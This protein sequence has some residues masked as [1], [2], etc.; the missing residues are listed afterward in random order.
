[1]NPNP[2]NTV[3]TPPPV[4]PTP[5]SIPPTPPPF[6]PTPTPKPPM[7]NG[8]AH[9]KMKLPLGILLVAVIIALV[10]LGYSKYPN[11]F[12][13]TNLPAE[14]VTIEKIDFS[15][16]E[17]IGKLPDGFPT[18]I[19]VEKSNLIESTKITYSEQKSVL[20][21]VSFNSARQ[22][23]ELY[24]QYK[25]FLSA[26]NGFVIDN[27]VKTVERMAFQATKAGTKDNITVAI[28]PQSSGAILVQ[29]S[30]VS[31]L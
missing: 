11:L 14:K 2:I 5:S 27:Q 22:S 21:S 17:N 19:P 3:P 28:T 26:K 29:I 31:K 1:M 20:Y 10:Y 12:K 24:A 9:S 23:E 4:T 25:D 8:D 15:K 30:Y 16:V 13:K 7:N 6:V 18:N